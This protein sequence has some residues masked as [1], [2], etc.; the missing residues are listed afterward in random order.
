MSNGFMMMV[1]PR[2]FFGM[3]EAA[4]GMPC[5]G[6]ARLASVDAS[7]PLRKATLGGEFPHVVGKFLRGWRVA[8]SLFDHDVRGVLSRDGLERIEAK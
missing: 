3:R 8:L 6:P 2:L 4:I 1:S 5:P 7:L